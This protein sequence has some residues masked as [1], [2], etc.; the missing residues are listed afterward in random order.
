[1]EEGRADQSAM[2]TLKRAL[3][4]IRQDA[5]PSDIFFITRRWKVHLDEPE[6]ARTLVRSTDLSTPLYRDPNASIEERVENLLAL[7]TLDE[8]LAQL[9]C[10]WS[11]AFVSTGPS[12]P[13]PLPRKCRTALGR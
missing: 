9:G 11:T 3:P 4:F 8:K 5:E 1:M 13:I 10:L 7:M 12:I 2:A 6:V